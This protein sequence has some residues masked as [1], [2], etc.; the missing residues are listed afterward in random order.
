M[1]R[2]AFVGSNPSEKSKTNTAFEPGTKSMTTLIEWC[3]KVH[4]QSGEKFHANVSEIKT[5]G[6][7]PLTKSEIDEGMGKLKARINSGMY[8]HIVALGKTAA[9][10]LSEYKIPHLDM[11]HP[12]GLNRKLN[13]SKYVEYCIDR[14]RSYVDGPGLNEVTLARTQ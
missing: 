4:L 6:N 12:S 2:V 13:D 11:P 9:N 14:L 10:A 7:R 8:T 5:P 1:R 3:D